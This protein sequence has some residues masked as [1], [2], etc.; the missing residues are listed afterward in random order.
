[1]EEE[2]EIRRIEDETKSKLHE[3]ERDLQNRFNTEKQQISQHYA[4]QR[5]TLEAAEQERFD[6]EIEKFKK[7]LDKLREKILD[8]KRV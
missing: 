1:M 5:Q 7:D 6:F 4:R 8:G 2:R 3:F